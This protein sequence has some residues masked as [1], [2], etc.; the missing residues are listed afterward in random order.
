MLPRHG[1]IK[2][3]DCFDVDS[4]EVMPHPNWRMLN[5]PAAYGSRNPR[6]LVLGFSKGATQQAIY[7]S[8]RLEDVA[9]A[10]M[11]PKLTEAL[12]VMGLLKGSDKV[13][14]W[15][16]NPEGYI[17]FGSLI[18]CS[19]SRKNGEKTDVN[20][21]SIYATS[22]KLINKSF[23]EIP[24]VIKHCAKKYLTNLPDSLETVILLG[25][26]DKYVQ[27][28]QEVIKS[29]YAESFRI[30]NDMWVQAG[31]K[32]WVHIAHPSP[33][34]GHFSKWLKGEGKQGQKQKM[35]KLSVVAL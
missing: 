2:C 9:F 17:A 12:R 13:D 33:A 19:A 24:N 14:Q 6:Y 3:Q 30:K 7:E 27:N 10:G 35:A 5:Q 31:G 4:N 21:D 18:R 15:I 29:L 11:R 8:G 1:K 23:N 32:N 20:G 28:C 22:G 26:D 16:A 25:N 34:N